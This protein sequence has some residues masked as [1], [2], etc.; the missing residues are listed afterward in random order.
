M[1]L[2]TILANVCDIR[3]PRNKLIN[4][5]LWPTLK[6]KKTHFVCTNDI[7]VVARRYLQML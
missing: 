6:K 2:K 5:L 3:K 4:I 1:L 7:K